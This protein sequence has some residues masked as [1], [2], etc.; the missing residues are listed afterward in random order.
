M[1][2]RGLLVIF[3][4]RDERLHQLPQLFGLRSGFINPF[5]L[6]DLHLQNPEVRCND[7]DGRFELM[8]RVGDKLLLLLGSSDNRVNGPAR[9]K[10]D[11]HI[12]QC[13]ADRVGNA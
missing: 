12:D 3:A 5:L 11:Q 1:Q 2:R 7:G 4:E 10:D 9:Q 8:P 6:P 13:K